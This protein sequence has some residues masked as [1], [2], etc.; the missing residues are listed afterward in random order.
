MPDADT[1]LSFARPFA[2]DIGYA[3]AV[4][5]RDIT[6]TSLIELQRIGQ[7]SQE[8]IVAWSGLMESIFVEVVGG[9]R[10]IGVRLP[11]EGV[12]SVSHIKPC[13]LH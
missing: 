8:Q 11:R 1:G 2:L 13:C 5:A 7:S 3:A 9:D 4:K 10:V 12:R 6:N